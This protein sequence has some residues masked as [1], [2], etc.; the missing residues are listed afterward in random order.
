MSLLGKA[1]ALF[2]NE[3]IKKEATIHFTLFIR[4]LLKLLTI[5]IAVGSNIFT[6]KCEKTEKNRT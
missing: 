6:F 4:A 1:L 5:R 3:N 2:K